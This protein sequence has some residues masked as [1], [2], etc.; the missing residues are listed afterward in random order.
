MPMAGRSA[1]PVASSC[2]DMLAGL[3][4]NEIFRTP[5]VFCADAVVVAQSASSNRLA[6]A[7]FR[8]VQIGRASC[9]ERVEISV[10]AV[11]L[12]KKRREKR[13]GC[14]RGRDSDNGRENVTR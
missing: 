8:K 2:N 4:K 14:V 10:G 5:P 3:S 11:S 12:R 9:R 7:R 1:A 13:H 6:A